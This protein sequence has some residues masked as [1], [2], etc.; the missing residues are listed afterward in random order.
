MSK[1]N[2][3]NTHGYVRPQ[4]MLR[5]AP[6][7]GDD[8]PEGQCTE[9]FLV[10]VPHRSRKKTREWCRGRPG[11]EHELAIEIP[12]NA[13]RRTCLWREQ[14]HWKE[15]AQWRY[16]CAHVQLCTACGKVFL[17]HLNSSWQGH[18]L[19]DQDC[20][21]YTEPPPYPPR[22]WPEPLPARRAKR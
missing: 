14:Y 17:R 11:R 10:T 5:G 22:P 15:P 6:E 20:P 8:Q 21:D 16:F 19:S 2:W 3:E 9:P 4:D 18:G 12:P 1:G 7:P 13:Y